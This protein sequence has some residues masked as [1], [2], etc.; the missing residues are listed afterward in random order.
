MVPSDLAGAGGAKVLHPCFLLIT[1]EITTRE[2]PIYPVSNKDDLPHA[3]TPTGTPTG[4]L[5][6]RPVLAQCPD[7]TRRLLPSSGGFLSAGELTDMKG[8]ES[9]RTAE[10]SPTLSWGGKEKLVSGSVMGWGLGSHGT[11]ATGLE[12]R[13]KSHGIKVTG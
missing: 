3:C 8:E 5:I 13:D 4:F 10:C 2:F 7:S 12:S 9:E 11:G 1:P 6:N